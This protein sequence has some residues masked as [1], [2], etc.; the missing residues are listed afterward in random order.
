MNKMSEEKPTNR[1]VFRPLCYD[2]EAQEKKKEEIFFELEEK[3]NNIENSKRRY[4]EE[5]CLT[6]PFL[7]Q[8]RIGTGY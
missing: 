3:L 1:G 6:N 4:R 8:V 7:K 5:D 2:F